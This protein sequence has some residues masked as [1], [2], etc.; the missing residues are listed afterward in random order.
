MDGVDRSNPEFPH[1]LD[2]QSHDVHDYVYLLLAQPAL[3]D[4]PFLEIA[5]EIALVAVLCDKDWLLP[6]LVNVL[7]FQEELASLFVVVLLDGP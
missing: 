2:A 7:Q 1:L 5:K 4:L 3:G 6:E